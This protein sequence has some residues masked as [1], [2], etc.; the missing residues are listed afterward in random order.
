MRRPFGVM[1]SAAFL[2]AV[3]GVGV[4]AR[5][6]TPQDEAA[7]L[8]RSLTELEQ[9]L[10]SPAPQLLPILNSL[11][12][13]QF[14]QGQFADATAERRRSLKIAI[15]AYGS[16]SVPAAEA[17]AA[18]VKLY[19]E[20]RRYLDAEPL[21]IIASNLL[22]DRLGESTLALAPVLADRARIALARGDKDDA[23][24]WAEEAVEIDRKN[25]TRQSSRLRVLG[26]V[27]AAQEQF[28]G[29]DGVLH[30]ALAL[31]RAVGNQFEIARSLA[32]LGDINLKQKKFV[33]ALPLIEEAALVDQ[34]NLGPTHPLIAEDLSDLG[35]IYLA[36]NRPGLA[37]K[38]FHS[39]IALLQYG[40]GR[41]TPTLAYI[42]LDLARAEHILGNGEKSQALF[43]AARRIL[44][45]AEDQEHDRQRSA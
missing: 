23:R 42:Q 16:A 35:L 17:M 4:A 26:E 44:N 25:G 21:A 37:V 8:T 32:A 1:A 30:Q 9:R 18:L 28:E 24:K 34:T 20:Q 33:E 7:A 6:G 13:L 10:G 38:V 40:A 5:P 39:A 19:I 15:A 41:N 29:S 45:A 2:S 31:A 14:Q 3:V 12:E 22:R 27:L 36:T 43:S 11:A